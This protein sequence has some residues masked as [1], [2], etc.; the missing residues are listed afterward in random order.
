MRNPSSQN[1]FKEFVDEHSPEEAMEVERE[2]RKHSKQKKD[3]CYTRIMLAAVA[4]MVIL[5]YFLISFL[6]EGE[7]VHGEVDYHEEGYTYFKSSMPHL[8]FLMRN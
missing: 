4:A 1:E 2:W 3:Q 8:K 7:R 5:F 6:S